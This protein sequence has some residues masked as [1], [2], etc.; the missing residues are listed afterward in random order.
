LPRFFT[1]AAAFINQ[2]PEH[3]K[4]TR[5]ALDFV[6]DHQLTRKTR[7]VKLGIFQLGKI[8][9]TF[10]IQVMRRFSYVQAHSQCRLTHLP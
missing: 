6:K 5:Q 4:Q 7:E 2:A 1:P 3:G 8:R 9:G 10:K